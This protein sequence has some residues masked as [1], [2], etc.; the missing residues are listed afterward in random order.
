MH[1]EGRGAECHS[2]QQER[3]E[4][5]QSA[6]RHNEKGVRRSRVPCDTTRGW[7]VDTQQGEGG[8]ES[9]AQHNEKGSGHTTREGG[10][11]V[12]LNTMRRGVGRSRAPDCYLMQRESPSQQ[13]ARQGEGG[14]VPLNT[15]IKSCG[16]RGGQVVMRVILRSRKGGPEVVVVILGSREGSGVRRWWLSSYAAGWGLRWRCVLSYV[17]GGGP[18]VI[19]IIVLGGREGGPEVVVVVL[20]SKEGSKVVVIVLHSREGNQRY[21][22][23]SFYVVNQG[24]KGGALS[25]YAVNQGT[26]VKNG[27][28]EVMHCHSTQ[29]GGGGSVTIA[30]EYQ[31]LLKKN[32]RDR[33]RQKYETLTIDPNTSGQCPMPNMPEVPN[34][35]LHTSHASRKEGERREEKKKWDIVIIAQCK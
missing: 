4:E 28:Q 2:T 6:T 31:V 22:V 27:G 11:R 24:T 16:M 19:I 29:Q 25:S 26:R 33:I 9:V 18:E 17:A 34:G 32:A 35:G 10:R 3:D 15:T 21:C 13:D 5:K 1:N 14:R 8:R 20:C 23:L 30:Y 12:L 7:G